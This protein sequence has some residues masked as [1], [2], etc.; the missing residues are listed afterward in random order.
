MAKEQ[1][2]NLQELSLEDM[3]ALWNQIKQIEKQKS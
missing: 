3:D 2:N 1:G